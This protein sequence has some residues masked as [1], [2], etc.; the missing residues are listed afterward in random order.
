MSTLNP[1]PLQVLRAAAKSPRGKEPDILHDVDWESYS[2]TLRR[3]EWS[4]ILRSPL[5]KK[6]HVLM[7]LCGPDGS[8]QRAT[9]TRKTVPPVPALYAGLRKT[10]W[11]GLYPALQN[12]EGLKSRHS[13]FALSAAEKEELAEKKARE[14]AKAALSKKSGGATPAEEVPVVSA[15][16]DR[17]ALSDTTGVEQDSVPEWSPPELPIQSEPER[18][19]RRLLRK[20]RG[21]ALRSSRRRSRERENDLQDH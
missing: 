14:Q 4:R 2:P 19:G 8:L 1:S 11:G 3:Q 6:G 7:D 17:N 16:L 21:A 20:Q 15:T 9:T 5:K 12:G 10:H 18:S 13:S